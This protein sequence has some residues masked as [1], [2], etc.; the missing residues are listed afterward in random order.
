[1]GNMVYVGI[2]TGKETFSACALNIEGTELMTPTKYE[3]G[4]EE[5][6]KFL[7]NAKAIASVTGGRLLFGIESTGIYHV[8]L[9][10]YLTKRNYQVRVFNGLELSGMRKSR[11]RKTKTDAIDA[12]L[13]AGYLL[14]CFDKDKRSPLPLELR[15]LRE[16]CRI[17][18]RLTRNLTRIK[19]QLIRDLDLIFPGFTGI[20][21]DM[22][23]KSCL[24]LLEEA[25]TP[26]EIIGMSK[27][28]LRKYVS[29]K[30]AV[31]LKIA[32]AKTTSVSSFDE[33]VVFEIGSLCRQARCL[34]DELSGVKKEI[35]SEYSQ[36]KTPLQSIPCIGPGTGPVIL[37]EIGDVKNFDH[38]KRIVGFAGIDP[39]IKESGKSRKE[40][41]ISKRGSASLRCALYQ[42]AFAGITC[43]PVIKAFYRKK[44]SE[45]K[46]HRDAVVCCARKLCYIIY[47]VLSNNRVFYVPS[48]II[49]SNAQMSKQG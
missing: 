19:N 13:I 31:K 8:P 2:D 25:C 4:R 28:K 15:N 47:S 42:A 46:T 36:I 39:V 11:I 18:K 45:G 35:D 16:F 49:A 3:H 27:E 20:F 37:A 40:C 48:H 29:E 14:M 32:A 17:K 23:G 10:D 26:K 7:G 22:L 34:L 1:M 12:R 5:Y 41:R 6:R 33:S 9:Y 43:N 21:S 24:E 38:P 44:R 30:H